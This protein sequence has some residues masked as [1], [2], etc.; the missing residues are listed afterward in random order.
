[1]GMSSF[2][3]RILPKWRSEENYS[4]LRYGKSARPKWRHAHSLFTFL[5][6]TSLVNRQLQL[7]RLI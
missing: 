2:W 5:Q 4:D 6:L 7:L 3:S 1:V